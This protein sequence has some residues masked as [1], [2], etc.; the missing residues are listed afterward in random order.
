MLLNN[1]KGSL[2]EENLDKDL[3]FKRN[4]LNTEYIQVLIQ[5]DEADSG[6]LQSTSSFQSASTGELGDVHI[7]PLYSS[8]SASPHQDDD[9]QSTKSC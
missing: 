3:I 7:N 5:I 4:I 9:T 2:E 6:G 8:F 1:R